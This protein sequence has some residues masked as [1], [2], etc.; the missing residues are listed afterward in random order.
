MEIYFN[1]NKRRYFAKQ[2][3]QIRALPPINT[4]LLNQ[5][6]S[7]FMIFFS[8]AHFRYE[9]PTMMSCTFVAFIVQSE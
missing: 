1:Y 8:Q 4:V 7:E 3:M 6:L 2:A 9:R 5:N